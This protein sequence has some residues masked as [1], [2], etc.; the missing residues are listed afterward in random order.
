[1]EATM[2]ETAKDHVIV[3]ECTGKINRII[4]RDTNCFNDFLVGS[5]RCARFYLKVHKFDFSSAP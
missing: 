1:M 4:A 5:L 3:T 2:N